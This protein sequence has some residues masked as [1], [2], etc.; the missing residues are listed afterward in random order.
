MGEAD[1]ARLPGQL[2]LRDIEATTEK[3]AGAPC[4][5]RRRGRSL[6]AGGGADWR[7]VVQ[8]GGH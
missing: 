8:I 2:S 5:A 4:A 1:D 6:G 7:G 3:D